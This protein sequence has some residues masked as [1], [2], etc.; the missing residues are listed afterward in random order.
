LVE[1]GG[2]EVGGPRVSVVIPNYDGVAWL[3]R[4]L[5]GLLAQD[6]RD[7]EIILVD[8]GSRD[9]SVALVRERYPAVRRIVLDR[10]LGFAA[11]VNRGI[12]VSRGAYVA[13]LNN[14]TVVEPG[15][16]SALVL[17]LERS[18]EEIGAVQSKMLSMENPDRID[19]AGDRLSWTGAAQK[20]GHGLPASEFTEPRE[21]FSPCAGAA[22]YRRSFLEKTRRFDEKFFAY[23]EDV[24]LGLRGRL[25]GYRYLFEPAARVLHRGYGSG[26]RRSVYVRLATR[27]RLLIFAKNVPLLLLVK[28]LPSLLYGQ[29][30]FFIVYRRPLQTLAG[31]LS[32]LSFLPHVLRERRRTLRSMRVSAAKLET[33]LTTEMGEPPMRRLLFGK[34]RRLRS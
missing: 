30:Y 10:N 16:L 33:M 1:V 5:D 19:D 13:L 18:P 21:I 32:F 2:V 9:E 17:A 31:F 14:D 4:C 15:W 3:A 25:L 7:F 34:L 22:L 28:H 11:A 27:N 6:L 26:I 24:D 29:V 23:L 8:N 20:E 12:A